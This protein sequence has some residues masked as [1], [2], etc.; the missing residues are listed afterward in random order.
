MV[1]RDGARNFNRMYGSKFLTGRTWLTLKSSAVLQLRIYAIYNR[2]KMILAVLIISFAAT[3]AAAL[4]IIIEILKTERG[5]TAL[6]VS[7]SASTLNS[8]SQLLQR[9]STDS[10]R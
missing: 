5:A 2:N 8:A 4:G 1:W 9:L 7:F 10:F 6:I 3:A